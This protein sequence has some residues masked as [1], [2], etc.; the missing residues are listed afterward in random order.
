MAG[1]TG[2]DWGPSG[3][4]P[5][6][7]R[8][9]PRAH[10]EAP[11]LRAGEPWPGPRYHPRGQE[12]EKQVGAGRRGPAGDKGAGSERD[13]KTRG[14]WGVGEVGDKD[15]GRD[16]PRPGQPGGARRGLCCPLAGGPE[17]RGRGNEGVRTL[18][19]R[20]DRRRGEGGSL[21]RDGDTE[22]N[23]G[24]GTARDR[25]TEKRDRVK[26]ME[27]DLGTKRRRNTQRET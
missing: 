6:D 9:R 20:G 16:S 4:E 26:G 3:K 22:R 12:Y 14:G 8:P 7:S 21:T 27:R 10:L 23:R 1:E 25:T 17:N 19:G 18:R 24:T 13:T 11:G 2:R 5:P 15:T